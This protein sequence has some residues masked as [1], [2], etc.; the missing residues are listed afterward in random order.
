MAVRSAGAYLC[1]TR[2]GIINPKVM[3]GVNQSLAL[4]ATDRLEA[5]AASELLDTGALPALDRV[6]RAAADLLAAPVAQLNVVTADRQ[7]PISH[8][9]GESWRH[10]VPLE[11]SFCRHVITSGEPLVVRDAREHP[12]LRENPVATR[13]EVKISEEIRASADAEAACGRSRG[14]SGSRSARST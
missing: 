11:H 8:I 14:S 4:S 5:I 2:I 13:D 12:L 9:A 6:V 1:R 3:Q 10:Q 7:I